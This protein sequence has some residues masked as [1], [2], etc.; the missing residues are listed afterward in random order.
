MA[1]SLIRGKYVICRV[2]GRHE[3][4]VIEDGAVFQRD[5]VIVEVGR[6][7]QLAAR[8]RADE[9]LGS[10]EHVLL[11]GFVNS[12]HHLGLTPL[13]MG[14]PDHPLELWWG[15]RLAK[16]DVDLYLD[17]LHSAFEMVE[18]GVTAVQHMQSRANGPLPRIEAAA[19]QVIKAYEDVGMRVSYSYGIREQNRLVYEPDEQFV[20][21]LPP[22]IA[23][24]I[25]AM[26][27][28]QT[29]PLEENFQLFESLHR[30]HAHK[31]R[32]RIQLAPTNLHWCTDKGLDIVRQYA[33][34][35]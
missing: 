20:K 28:A 16:R 15:S 10:P 4:Q 34:K 9:T 24:E 13:Q 23:P 29:I 17:T 30:A 19:N 8:H 5:G 26:L 2:T 31:E 33:E 21:R 18:S 22:D 35:Y 27:R 32:V 7:P 14:S 11:P 6:Y 1:S 25:A 12:H 3:A